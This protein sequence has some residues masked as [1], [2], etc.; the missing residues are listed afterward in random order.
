[1]ES[2]EYLA[3]LCKRKNVVCPFCNVTL[4]NDDS[5]VRYFKSELTEQRVTSQQNTKF[6][7]IHYE[8][9]DK[10][11][12]GIFKF[13]EISLLIIEYVK[14]PAC[15]GISI[16][17]HRPYTEEMFHILPKSVSKNYPN[18]VPE[19]IRQDYQEACMIADLSPKAS[20]TL[21]RRC[22]QCMIRDFWGIS[23]NRLID[24]INEL[25]KKPEI[26]VEQYE[27][28]DAL[29]KIGNIGGHPNREPMTD[30]N[31]VTDIEPNEVKLMIYIIEFF[32]EDWYIKR[33]NNAEKMKKIKQIADDKQNKVKQTAPK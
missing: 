7:K 16:N 10:I 2:N 14:C 24:E 29:R 12:D 20:A 9:C 11:L 19:A 27:S 31:L 25:A 22:L 18:Y 13:N 6:G 23:K 28:I 8:L 21:L 33:H 3:N 30:V 26:D 15:G 32:I 5:T 17:V 1:M 4:F